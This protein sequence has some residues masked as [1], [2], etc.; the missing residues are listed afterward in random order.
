MLVFHMFGYRQARTALP[1][2]AETRGT[3]SEAR[4]AC[5]QARSTESLSFVLASSLPPPPSHSALFTHR[6][7]GE[8]K[9]TELLHP[10]LLLPMTSATARA[11]SHPQ[12]LYNQTDTSQLPSHPG[13]YPQKANMRRSMFVPSFEGPLPEPRR[14]QNS[15]S[16]LACPDW[17]WVTRHSLLPLTSAELRPFARVRAKHPHFRKNRGRGVNCQ[18]AP[19]PSVGEKF[20]PGNSG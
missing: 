3:Q 13:G 6:N 7:H 11:H 10:S 8:P 2:C 12:P 19:L 14:N 16:S 20:A 5:P 18:K 4:R 9:P 15:S 17:V 1:A